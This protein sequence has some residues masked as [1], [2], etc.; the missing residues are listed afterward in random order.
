MLIGF[1]KVMV[2]AVKSSY[3]IILCEIQIN[4]ISL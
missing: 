3:E 1:V 4:H 2:Q